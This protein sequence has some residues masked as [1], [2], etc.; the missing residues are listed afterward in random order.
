MRFMGEAGAMM[1][2]FRQ[3]VQ[4]RYGRGLVG[5]YKFCYYS[6]L[7][8]NTFIV[9]TCGPEE[10]PKQVMPPQL[11]IVR[12]DLAQL[13]AVRRHYSLPQEFYCDLNHNVEDFFLGFWNDAPA[14]LHWIFQAGKSSRFLE[15]GPGCAEVNYMLT[16]PDFRGRRLCSLVV[17]HTVRELGAEGVRRFFCVVHDANI[18]SIKAVQRSGFRKDKRVRSF[19]PFNGRTKVCAS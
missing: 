3:S 5:V 12:G 13:A 18:A 6:L 19:G 9:F 2:H 11:R 1:R 15:L 14:Y 4:A 17:S 8:I 16:L 7:R 10:T